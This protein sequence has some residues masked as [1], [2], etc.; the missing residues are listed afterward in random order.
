M[1]LYIYILSITLKVFYLILLFTSLSYASNI[2]NSATVFMYHKF[3]VDKYPSTSVTIEQLES[4]IEELTKS[5]YNILSLEFIVDTIINDGNLPPNSIGISI[6][7]ADKSFFDVGWP[8]FKKNNIPV[9]L[10]VTTGTNKNS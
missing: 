3:G 10:F 8:Y 7:D 2:K 1:K 4:H 5:K 9:T 6:D